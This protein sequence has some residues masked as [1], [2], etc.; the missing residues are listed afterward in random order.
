MVED[1]RTALVLEDEPVVLAVFRA[2]LQRNGFIVLAAE[3]GEVALRCSSDRRL[4]IDIVVADITLPGS[5][6][7]NVVLQIKASRPDIPVLFTSGRPLDWLSAMDQG[8]I[9][10]LPEGSYSFLQKPF[11][12]GQLMDSVET[13][14]SRKASLQAA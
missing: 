11:T 1:A 5:S 13:L 8:N 4:R 14:L 2:V 7:T 12:A 9:A 3:R 10:G 6:G